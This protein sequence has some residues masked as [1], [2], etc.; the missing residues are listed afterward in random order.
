M[1]DKIKTVA[2]D[3]CPLF[4]E[5]GSCDKC[6]EEIYIDDNTCVYQSMAKLFLE[7]DYRKSSDVALEAIDHIDGWFMYCEKYSGNVI[8]MRL[9]ELKKKCTEGEG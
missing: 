5:Y 4:K 3:V 7:K 8:K 6:D 2:A 9:A 1:N